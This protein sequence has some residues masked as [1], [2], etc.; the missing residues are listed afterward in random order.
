MSATDA[1]RRTAR[2]LALLVASG[3]AL[4][5]VLTLGVVYAGLGVR[6][7]GSSV[8]GA[9]PCVAAV[10]EDGAARVR[11]SVLPPRA[12]CAWEV[13]GRREEVVVASAP[14]PLVLVAATLAV[15]GTAGAAVV[16]VRGR[17]RPNG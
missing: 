10:E 7:L 6:A 1:R 2:A 5:G 3:L 14:A 17:A 12:V 15:A 8:E 13:D 4:V 9:Q 16:L 11:W